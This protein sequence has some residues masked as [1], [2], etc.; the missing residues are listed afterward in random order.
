M[1]AERAGELDEPLD[2]AAADAAP[3]PAALDVDR[4]VGHVV[5]RGSWVEVVEAAPADDLAASL[6][7]DH[8]MARAARSHPLP[9][10]RGRAELGLQRGQTVLDALVVD[11]A[12]RRRVGGRRL[13]HAHVAHGPPSAPTMA[14]VAPTGK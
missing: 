14:V 6:G 7:D 11:H 5:V 12:D 13:P 8:R 3:A 1:I 9:A 10:L 4:D 2:Q